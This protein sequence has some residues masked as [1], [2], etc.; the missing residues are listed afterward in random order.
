M[1]NW[2]SHVVR[3]VLLA[4]SM[5]LFLLVLSLVIGIGRPDTGPA[6][7]VV[8]AAAVVGLIALGVNVQR[9]RSRLSS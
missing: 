2:Q 3:L 1:K 5:V 8:L 4:V 9:A 7:K 6:E